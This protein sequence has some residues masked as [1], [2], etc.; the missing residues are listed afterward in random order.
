M[1]K[2][3]Y[4]YDDVRQSII[5]LARIYKPNTD[6]VPDFV[7]EFVRKYNVHK[8]YESELEQLV[9]ETIGVSQP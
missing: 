3:K 1:E 9:Y 6:R 8:G 7:R 5:D 2:K 4:K